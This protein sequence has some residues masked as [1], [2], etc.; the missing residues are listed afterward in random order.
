LL[1]VEGMPG[2]SGLPPG[3]LLVVEDPDERPDLQIQSSRSMGDGSTDVCDHGPP[4]E[5]G[6]IPGI[7]PPDFGPGQHVTDALRDFACR[8]AVQPESREA[9]TLDNLGDFAFRDGRS[10]IQYCS[11][12]ASVAAF[13][14][15]KTVV[16]AR[17]RDVGG[18]LGP[19]AQ[20]VVN[21][22]TED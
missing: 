19:A 4:P 3:I 10:T 14:H 21:N 18:N 11:Q 17:L 5:G 20:I 15:G 2:A 22:E 16:T 7:D 12:T 6:G 8:F 13:P 9:C 1:V